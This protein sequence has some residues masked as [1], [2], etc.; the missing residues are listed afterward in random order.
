LPGDTVAVVE[1]GLAFGDGVFRTILVRGGRPLNWRWHRARLQADCATLLLP[2]PD[3]R[4][5][6]AEIAQA[7]PGDATVK[8]TITRGRATRGYGIARDAMPTRIV[9]AFPAPAY[10]ASHAESGVTVRRCEMVLSQQPRLAGAKTLNRLENVLARSEWDDPGI[11]EGLLGDAEGRV[12]EGTMSNVF[13]VAAG[14]LVTPA[15]DRCGV[16]GA[17]RERIRELA[18]GAAIA[19]SERPV[20][21]SELVAA[22]EVFLSNSLIGIWPVVRYERREWAVGSVTRRLHSLLEADDARA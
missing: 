12:V 20:P 16:I 8:V 14:T 21:W 22:D 13:I 6:L 11:A 5:L 10:P 7:A 2:P 3:E 1:R 4:M 18:A 17:Q 15:L 19:C 9:S